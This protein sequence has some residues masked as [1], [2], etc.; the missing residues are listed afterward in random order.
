MDV[1]RPDLHLADERSNR[2]LNQ[3]TVDHCLLA[4]M[5][6]CVFSIIASIIYLVGKQLSYISLVLVLVGNSYMIYNAFNIKRMIPA[7]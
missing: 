2:R 7:L 6:L 1:L 4:D 3:R 5:A